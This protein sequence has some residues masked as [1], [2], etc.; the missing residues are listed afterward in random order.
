MQL[1]NQEELNK[2]EEQIRRLKT[3]FDLFFMG[4]RKLPPSTDR[5]QVEEAVREMGKGKLRDNT[6]RFRYNTLVARYNRYQELWSRQMRELEEGPTDYRRRKAALEAEA[7]PNSPAETP[8]APVTSPGDDAYVK[9]TAS[10][11]GDAI[12]ALHRQIAE[13]NKEVGKTVPTEAQVAALVQKQLE[14]MTSKYKTD[15]V[16]FR[17]ETVDGKVRLRAKPLSK[18]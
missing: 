14:Q 12:R 3:Q 4:V 1:P 8:K 10:S 5:K 2:L 16:A 11:N 7:E 18:G 15:S 13:A 6:S 9:V 17:V